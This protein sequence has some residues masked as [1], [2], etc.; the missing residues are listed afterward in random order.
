[1]KKRW[2]RLPLYIRPALYFVYRYRLRLGFLD[3]KQGLIFHFFQGF[4]YRL[5]VDIIIDD[6]Y[7]VGE[8][9]QGP[10]VYRLPDANHDDKADGAYL[11]AA[12]KA[13]NVSGE[14]GLRAMP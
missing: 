7:A 14:F 11:I 4:W 3:G 8:G 12:P 2:Y 13:I 1:M 6:L 5:L 10:G 9:P